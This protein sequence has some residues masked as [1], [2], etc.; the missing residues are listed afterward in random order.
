MDLGGTLAGELYKFNFKGLPTVKNL[1]NHLYH[2]WDT[3]HNLD[4][5]LTP[6]RH[7]TGALHDLKEISGKHCVWPDWT[8]DTPKGTGLKRIGG[9]AINHD[10]DLSEWFHYTMAFKV[11]HMRMILYRRN[12][13]D[14][15]EPPPSTIK[16]KGK[17]KKQENLPAVPDSP[18]LSP[19]EYPLYLPARTIDEHHSLGFP[20]LPFRTCEGLTRK[21]RGKQRKGTKSD[22]AAKLEEYETRL[23]AMSSDEEEE[24]ED[25]SEGGV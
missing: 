18:I 21:N 7:I 16:G 20:F 24:E 9:L 23:A 12:W 3:N 8:G 11:R 2:E 4:P 15:L 10:R 6:P 22:V 25:D 1:L 17:K 13:D 14:F 19:T 5:D